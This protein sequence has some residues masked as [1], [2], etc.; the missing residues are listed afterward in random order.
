M[1]HV[2]HFSPLSSLWKDRWWL[3]THVRLI[4]SRVLASWPDPASGRMHIISDALVL[5]LPLPVKPLAKKR[6]K[7]PQFVVC[8]IK[9]TVRI[10]DIY[11]HSEFTPWHNLCFVCFSISQAWLCVER[12]SWVHQIYSPPGAG[13]W[14]AAQLSPNLLVLLPIYQVHQRLTSSG[15]CWPTAWLSSLISHLS[16]FLPCLSV[17]A[18]V[19]ISHWRKVFILLLS[20]AHLGVNSKKA[21]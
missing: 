8:V 12:L 20:Y 15:G 19:C 6:Q 21:K 14:S 17:D 3:Q 9:T 10:W 16:L 5:P 2:G 4:A 7:K 13:V 11:Y 1:S 18:T